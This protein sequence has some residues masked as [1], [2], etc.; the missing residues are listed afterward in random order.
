M[1]RR[2]ESTRARAAQPHRRH[3]VIAS[4]SLQALERRQLLHAAFE[5]SFN[6]QPA[7]APAVTGYLVDAGQKYGDRG[8]GLTYGWNA[9]NTGNARDRNRVADQRYDTLVQMQAGGSF[10]WEFAL[11]NGDYQVRVVAG[12]PSFND[13]VYK[14]NVEGVLTVDGT[15]TAA[16]RFVEGT[17]TVTVA[18]GKLTIAN[19]AGARNNK[20]AFVELVATHDGTPPPPPPPPGDPGQTPYLNTPFAVPGTIEA[21]F[22]DNGG[23]G[24]AWFDTTSGNGGGANARPGTS[25]DLVANSFGG[26]SVTGIQAREWLEYTVDVAT[27]GT[28]GLEL[29]LAS[30]SNGGTMHVEV[31]G[32][33]VTGAIAVPKTGGWDKFVT[34]TRSGIGMTAG[35]HLVRVSFDAEATAGVGI[36]RFDSLKFTTSAQQPQ[37]FNWQPGTLG[38]ITRSEAQ[39]ATIGTKIYMFG[40]FVDQTYAATLRSDVYDTATDTWSRIA[41]M[42]AAVTHAAVV[43]RGNDIYLIGGMLSVAQGKSV[44]TVYRYNVTS[45]TWSRLPDLPASSYG[46]AAGIVGSRIYYSGGARRS[47]AGGTPTDVGD[48]WMLDLDDTSAGWSARAAI[49]NR[50]NHVASAVVNGIVYV[51]GGQLLDLEHTGNVAFVDAYDPD[52]NRWTSMPALPAARSHFHTSTFVHQGRIYTVG[53]IKN[54]S[55]AADEIVMFD[56]ATKTWT[57]LGSLP[58]GRMNPVATLVGDTIYAIDGGVLVNGNMMPIRSTLKAKLLAAYEQLTAAPA[59]IG[60]ATG[61]VINGRLYAA[62]EGGA[63]TYVLNLATNT[64]ATA[65]ARPFAGGG[66]ASEVIDGKWYLVG[67]AGAS[68]G[69]LQVYDPA[70]NAWSAG[71]EAPWAVSNAAMAAIDGKLYVAGGFVNGA[72][73]AGAAVYDPATDAWTPLPDLPLAVARAGFGTDGARFYVF[74]GETAAGATAVVQV[75]DPQTG[76]WSTSDDGAE[77]P[78]PVARAGAGRAVFVGGVFQLI[79]GEAAVAGASG[80][81]ADGVFA[82]VDVYDPAADAWR[83]GPALPTPRHGVA[84]AWHAGR[85]Y[86]V[87]GS[88]RAGA[89]TSTTAEVLNLG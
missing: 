4:P 43:Q 54:G 47:T 15:P 35:R 82:R 23:S 18:D 21:E 89:G 88:S 36:G 39:P 78:L 28:Y 49:P 27:A 85:L 52:T 32:V 6:F 70:A 86:V 68:A 45:N 2:R 79:G 41:D 84:T 71:T 10:T 44:S 67:G 29:R 20:I 80:L 61:G 65:A 73:H 87:G 72:A 38:A 8:N 1:F 77:K 26:F 62:G 57:K 24:V 51:M 56:P 7:S 11:P 37:Y 50:R 66:H 30:G 22:F 48:H 16:A 3:V 60:N 33:N 81:T 69:K 17:K 83:A 40:G 63:G 9:A 14:I 76:T 12:D 64:W 31:D 19:A 74:G 5:A 46:G 55:V 13:S 25:V 59:A 75:F 58:Q 42:P 34:V 53:G